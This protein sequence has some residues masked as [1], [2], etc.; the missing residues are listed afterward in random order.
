MMNIKLFLIKTCLA[1]T[2]TPPAGVPK[3]VEELILAITSLL[4]KLAT[5]LAVILYL[6]AAFLYMT[7]GGKEENIK[8]ANL[9]V[10]YTTIGLAVILLAE[11]IANI[12]KGIFSGS[13]S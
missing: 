6:W 5:P 1:F 11:V 2:Y 13:P 10:I 4:R 12:V 8:K 9:A 3:S 7:A